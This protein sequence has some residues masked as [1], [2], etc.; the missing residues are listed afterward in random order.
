[1][2]A[3]AEIDSNRRAEVARW[4]ICFAIVASA[5]G[6]GALALLNDTSEASDFGVNFPVVI[7]DLPESFVPLMAPDLGRPPGPLEDEQTELMPPKE[8]M[9]PPEPEAEVKIPILEPP[10][11]DTPDEVKQATAPPP[12]NAPRA[13]IASW[14]NQ[15]MTHIE[16]FKRYP[17]KAR[18][19][20]GSANP[21][22]RLGTA[23]VSF[24]IDHEG[25]VLRSRIIQ[26]SGS[27]ELDDEAL[28][29]PARA[30]PLPRPP[31]QTPDTELTIIFQMNFLQPR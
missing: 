18:G 30:Q 11:P 10:K 7:V 25:H 26:S 3:V 23:K 9:K 31:D 16:G 2:N 4:V 5:H 28:G 21:R 17:D 1:V 8:E 20:L 14:Q 13:A 29:T 12:A 24:T 19:R 15:L 22:G 27:A 6:L